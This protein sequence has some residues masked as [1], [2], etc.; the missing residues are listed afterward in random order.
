MHLAAKLKKERINIETHSPHQE[1]KGY[2]FNTSTTK[3]K[4][5]TS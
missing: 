3:A 4:R 2:M 5:T 1:R